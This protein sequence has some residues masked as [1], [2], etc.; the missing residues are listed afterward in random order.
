MDVNKAVSEMFGPQQ[1]AFHNFYHTLG[2]KALASLSVVPIRAGIDVISLAGDD[3]AGGHAD[4]TPRVC[5]GAILDEGAVP[6]RLV[7]YQ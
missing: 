2:E 1:V 6:H 7:T 3:R 4:L 5:G